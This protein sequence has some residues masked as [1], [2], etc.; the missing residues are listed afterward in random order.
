[1]E[2][3][4]KLLACS[5]LLNFLIVEQNRLHLHFNWFMFDWIPPFCWHKAIICI[6]FYLLRCIFVYVYN[7]FTSTKLTIWSSFTLWIFL[8]VFPVTHS[9]RQTTTRKH[10]NYLHNWYLPINWINDRQ[11][12]FFG[13][14]KHTYLIFKIV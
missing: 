13:I 2:S 1:M 5:G 7:A 4:R 10:T 12:D 11:I 14:D 6:S 8:I 9:S 3:C